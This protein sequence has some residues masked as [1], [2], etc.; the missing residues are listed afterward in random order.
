[1][2]DGVEM[3]KREKRARSK[4]LALFIKE[5]QKKVNYELGLYKMAAKSVRDAARDFQSADIAYSKKASVRNSTIY[6][7]TKA[8]LIESAGSYKKA[9]ARVA[10]TIDSINEAY[11]EYAELSQ[12]PVKIKMEC[13]KYNNSVSTTI[14]NIQ[15]M[16][17]GVEIE[18]APSVKEEEEVNNNTYEQNAAQEAPAQENPAYATPAYAAPAYANPVYAN[19]AY[20]QPAYMPPPAY[21]APSYA[22]PA[23]SAPAYPSYDPTPKVAPVSIDV[24]AIVE[25]AIAATM[26]KFSEALD[27]RIETYMEN[28][29]LNIPAPQAATAPASVLAKTQGAE[30]IAVLEGTILEDEQFLIDKLTSMVESIKTL[31]AQVAE[32]SA[33]Y[34]EIASKSADANELQKQTNDMQ[35]RTLREQQGIQVSQRVVAQDQMVVAQAQNALAEQQKAVQDTQQALNDAQNA[36]NEA[37]NALVDNQVALEENVKSVMQAQ[38]DIIAAQQALVNGNNKNAEAQAELANRQAEALALQ[39]EALASQKQLL[40]EQKSALEKQRDLAASSPKKKTAKATVAETLPQAPEAAP[41]E[42]VAPVA[43]EVIAPVAEEVA[44]EA[45]EA[46]VAEVAE[47]V[48][49]EATNE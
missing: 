25:K 22:P 21:V 23:Y 34:A 11:A 39:K 38:K 28:Y 20:A 4:E 36:V 44:E 9:G 30:E 42:V 47:E 16:I 37:Q 46:V 27:K 43:E 12:N 41:E 13:D 24:S 1:M 19:P 14:N 6:E 31:T 29:D 17:D 40:R 8:V 33:A 26:Q 45:A 2:R 48:V 5:T 49:A 32:L 18:D 35:R 10:A 15:S 3:T 7:E